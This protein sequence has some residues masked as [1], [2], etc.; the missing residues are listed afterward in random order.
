MNIRNIFSKARQGI[1]KFEF[2]VA[3]KIEYEFVLLSRGEI[4]LQK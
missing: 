2:E 4:F 1:S 3:Y